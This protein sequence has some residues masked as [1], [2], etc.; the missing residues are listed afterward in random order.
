MDTKTIINPAIES[1][2]QVV[3]DLFVSLPSDLG[4]TY[5][6]VSKDSG[7]DF[8]KYRN[9][10]SVPSIKSLVDGFSS[11]NRPPDLAFFLARNVVDQT[12]TFDQARLVLKDWDLCKKYAEGRIEELLKRIMEITYT[13]IE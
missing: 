11:L 10:G 13:R 5:A 6:Q 9:G 4:L 12:I 3:T 2:T 1:V 7:I 8:Y